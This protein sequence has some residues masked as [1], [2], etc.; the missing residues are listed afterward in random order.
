MIAGIRGVPAL[1]HFW[2]LESVTVLVTGISN[3]M[4]SSE[5][6]YLGWQELYSSPP[7]LLV[8]ALSVRCGEI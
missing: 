2:T 3:V 5:H 1:S 4:A 6:C 7:L 8:K